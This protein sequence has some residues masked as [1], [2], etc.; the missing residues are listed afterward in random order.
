MAGMMELVM[1]REA[2]GMMGHE[3][4]LERVPAWTWG[5]RAVD[6]VV[7]DAPPEVVALVLPG[8]RF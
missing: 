8:T 3:A 1:A 5:L 7:T 2:L 6:A 4:R